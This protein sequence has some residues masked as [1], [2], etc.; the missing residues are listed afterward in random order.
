VIPISNG[1]ALMDQKLKDHWSNLIRPLFKH[2]VYFQI[3]DFKDHFEV[4]VFWELDTDPSR[5]RKPSKTIQII[6][7]WETVLDY[8]NKSDG[9]QKNDDKKLIQFIKSKLENF[10]PNHANPMSV[11]PPEVRWI[12]I[13]S[14]MNS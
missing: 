10:E 12:A 2:D 5:P 1:G 8:Q 4:E 14:I 7:P 9:R 13:T 3:K 11:P 6:V